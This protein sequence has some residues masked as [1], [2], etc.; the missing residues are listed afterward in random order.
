MMMEEYRGGCAPGFGHC[1]FLQTNRALLSV[2]L[3][4]Y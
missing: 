2:N 1:A 3:A 4:E